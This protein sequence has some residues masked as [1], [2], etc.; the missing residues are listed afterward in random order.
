MKISENKHK[1][2]KHYLSKAQSVGLTEAEKTEFNL[3][4]KQELTKKQ[5][6]G[7]NNVDTANIPSISLPE[8]NKN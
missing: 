6:L 4:L 3:L 8:T 7:K 1:K 5:V 2:F